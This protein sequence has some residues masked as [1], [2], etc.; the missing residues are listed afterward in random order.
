[1]V[2]NT[3]SYKSLR[4]ALKQMKQGCFEFTMRSLSTASHAGSWNVN[5][6]LTFRHAGVQFSY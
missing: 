1:M 4:R 6:T 2:L 3:T 5:N